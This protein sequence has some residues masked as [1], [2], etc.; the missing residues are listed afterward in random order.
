MGAEGRSVAGVAA[1]GGVS[2]ADDVARCGVV[3]CKLPRMMGQVLCIEHRPKPLTLREA[4]ANGPKF[5]LPDQ[6]WGGGPPPCCATC[7]TNQG[8]LDGVTGLCIGCWRAWRFSMG[9]KS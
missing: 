1:E 9:S 4:I 6:E 5:L 3:N 2:A 7:R 8:E